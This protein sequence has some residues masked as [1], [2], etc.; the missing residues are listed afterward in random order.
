MHQLR[1]LKNVFHFQNIGH[2]E[3]KIQKHKTNLLTK[4]RFYI[5]SSSSHTRNQKEGSAWQGG[6]PGTEA[7]TGGDV[8]GA[9][10]GA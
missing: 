1:I 2:C 7:G 10:Q 3:N 6:S 9:E 8:Q 5:Q 4:T